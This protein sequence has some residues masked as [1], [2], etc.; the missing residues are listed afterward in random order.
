MT[1]HLITLIALFVIQTSFSQ[2]SGDSSRKDKQSYLAITGGL[3]IPVGDFG[4]YNIKNNG[5]GFANNGFN[6]GISFAHVFWKNMGVAAMYRF[7]NNTINNTGL[8][9]QKTASQFPDSAWSTVTTPWKVNILMAGYYYSYPLGRAKKI[10][11]DVKLMLGGVRTYSSG[12]TLTAT[13]GPN[14]LSVAQPVSV[15]NSFGYCVGFGFKYNITDDVYLLLHA[16]Y[17]QSKPDFKN[18]SIVSTVSGTII[19]LNGG[20]TTQNFEQKISTYNLSLGIGVKID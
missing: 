8:T 10:Y 2:T 18:V 6:A 11:F 13:L 3:S 7:Q 5:A 17:L 9:N 14:L 15:A 16:D 19:G 12:Y 1:K 4:S 20:V